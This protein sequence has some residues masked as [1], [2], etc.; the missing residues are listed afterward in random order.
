MKPSTDLIQK[1]FQSLLRCKFTVTI[2]LLLAT[3]SSGQTRISGRITDEKTGQPIS[4]VE[5]FINNREQAETVTKGADFLVESDSGIS[6]ATFI[7]RNYKPEI[8]NFEDFR[9]ENLVVKLQSEKVEQINEVVISGVSKKSIK[10]K[11]KIRPTP[12][13]RKSGNAVKQTG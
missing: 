13:C 9:F 11:K 10:T 1:N 3:L 2:L 7:K 12:S 6:T 8:L 5:I 4:G